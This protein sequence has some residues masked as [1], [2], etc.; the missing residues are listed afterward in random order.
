MFLAS[1]CLYLSF[2]RT[3][4]QFSAENFVKDECKRRTPELHMLSTGLFQ[5]TKFK[6]SE[7]LWTNFTSLIFLFTL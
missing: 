7:K 5:E 4:I 2:R 3:Q 6:D 1:L